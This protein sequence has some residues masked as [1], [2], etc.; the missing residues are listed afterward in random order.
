[1]GQ[2]RLRALL[3]RVAIC[4]YRRTGK[5]YTLET[6]EKRQLDNPLS[7]DILIPLSRTH[8]FF[9]VEGSPTELAPSFQFN[10]GKSDCA[11]YSR[12]LRERTLFTIPGRVN[13]SRVGYQC[14]TATVV[15]LM[16]LAV[17]VGLTVLYFSLVTFFE[18]NAKAL[19]AKALIENSL[20]AIQ[21]AAEKA[22]EKA[23]DVTAPDKKKAG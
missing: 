5:H 9:F 1:M 4:F 11:F 7:R 12:F 23:K 3:E 22:N 15:G 2:L 18:V 21:K 6:D 19:D 13:D 14:E 8:D 17:G 20:S 10:Q 16:G